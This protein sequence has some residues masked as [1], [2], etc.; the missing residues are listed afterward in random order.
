MCLRLHLAQSPRTL[1]APRPR[2]AAAKIFVHFFA[3]IVQFFGNLLRNSIYIRIFAL[4][5]RIT[6]NAE[7]RPANVKGG[8]MQKAERGK[9]RSAFFI[10]DNLHI[11]VINLQIALRLQTTY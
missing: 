9:P 4:T 5:L 8:T 6:G 7:E 2:R 11:L 1:L 3:K 10:P